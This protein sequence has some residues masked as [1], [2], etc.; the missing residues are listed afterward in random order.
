ME[1]GMLVE[2]K[3]EDERQWEAW[4]NHE[5]T[6]LRRSGSGFRNYVVEGWG[7][8]G[9]ERVS[10]MDNGRFVRDL[11]IF[12]AQSG[13]DSVAGIVL[14][15]AN[16]IYA[17]GIYTREGL[18]VY[19]LSSRDAWQWLLKSGSGGVKRLWKK[20]AP[21]FNENFN[22]GW[23]D[24]VKVKLPL[25]GN[26]GFF[27]H[28]LQ[29]GRA[30]KW[31]D[32]EEKGW[33]LISGSSN[34]NL[35]RREVHDGGDQKDGKEGKE[36]NGQD[37]GQGNGLPWF[38]GEPD[39]KRT[40]WK[41]PDKRSELSRWKGV[42]WQPDNSGKTLVK[43]NKIWEEFL[44]DNGWNPDGTRKGESIEEKVVIEEKEKEEY[45]EHLGSGFISEKFV[46]VGGV[47][48]SQHQVS[49][50]ESH[51]RDQDLLFKDYLTIFKETYIVFRY[52]VDTALVE[53]E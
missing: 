19:E 16:R 45:P 14:R 50:R 40:N 43:N 34:I 18:R 4:L 28:T 11:A 26:D 27:L 17:K 53:G 51:P 47:P 23:D 3:G 15:G 6:K 49:S 22:G 52:H 5:V 7:M 9:A 37:K 25:C 21:L 35:E 24:G 41:D 32:L 30:L 20:E 10:Q 12:E 31:A 36:S 44:E 38:F 46:K 1:A 39:N 48:G 2:R 8:E 29:K 42:G 13:W 33:D